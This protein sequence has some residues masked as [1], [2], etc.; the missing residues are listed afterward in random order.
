MVNRAPRPVREW[1][2]RSRSA[3]VVTVPATTRNTPTGTGAGVP[4]PM[5][6][7]GPGDRVAIDM[8]ALAG[9]GLEAAVQTLRQ[10]VEALSQMLARAMNNPDDTNLAHYQRRFEEAFDQLR[11]A[12]GS[13]LALRKSRGELAPRTEFRSD[14]HTL[15]TG[16]RGMMRRRADN[17][18][19]ALADA[20][21][22]E[23]LGL[24][25]AAVVAEG[26]R[27]EQLLRS[28]RYW[29]LTSTGDIQLPAA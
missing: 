19:S 3:P 27:D 21:T 26:E 11:K 10:N 23:Q 7:G 16:L 5:G 17:I 25:R 12:E 24:V 9:H 22:P 20:L 29:Q 4:P 1:A 14:L 8:A 6:Q 18:C 28:S 15:M 2:N 13:L